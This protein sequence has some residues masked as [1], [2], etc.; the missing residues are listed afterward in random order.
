MFACES[1]LKVDSKGCAHNI[2]KYSFTEA[3][4][5]FGCKS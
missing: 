3:I 5:D 4:S 2:E 1:P